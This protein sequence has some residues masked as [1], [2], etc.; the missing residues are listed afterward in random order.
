MKRF[1]LS[2]CLVFPL[3]VYAQYNARCFKM[4]NNASNSEQYVGLTTS[5]DTTIQL[6]YPFGIDEFYITGFASLNNWD[7]GYIRVTLTDSYNM[8]YLVYELYPLLA[9]SLNNSCHKISIETC[10]LDNIVPQNINISISNASF[11]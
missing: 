2:I 3:C 4:S 9:D 11:S 1:L 5:Q 10:L 7:S 8:E 6:N